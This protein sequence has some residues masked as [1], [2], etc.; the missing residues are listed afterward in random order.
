VCD[1][2]IHGFPKPPGPRIGIAIQNRLGG[3]IRGNIIQGADTGILLDE[4]S[5][6]FKVLDNLVRNPRDL[7]VR[8]HGKGNIVRRP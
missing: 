1:N 3:L 4:G 7:D 5:S 8:D 6:E 2:T